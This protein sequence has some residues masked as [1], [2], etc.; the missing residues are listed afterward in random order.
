LTQLCRRSENSASFPAFLGRDEKMFRGKI[1][2][3]RSIEIML[4]CASRSW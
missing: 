1:V 2:Q 4:A 3:S